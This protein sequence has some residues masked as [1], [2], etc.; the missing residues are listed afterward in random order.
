MIF[1]S[2]TQLYEFNPDTKY[3]VSYKGSVRYT[4]VF[5]NDNYMGLAENGNY[6]SPHESASFSLRGWGCDVNR[7]IDEFD[8]DRK[9]FMK[10]HLNEMSRRIKYYD[11]AFLYQKAV[12]KIVNIFPELA[13]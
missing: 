9:K 10:K 8:T 12:D 7:S 5:F 1:N 11:Q 13:I 3:W 4:T 2:K 6:T